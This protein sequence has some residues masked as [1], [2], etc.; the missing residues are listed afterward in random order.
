[1]NIYY[2]E[3]LYLV[4]DKMEINGYVLYSIVE[5]WIFAQVG[6]A[7]VVAVDSWYIIKRDTKLFEKIGKLICLK[8]H[9]QRRNTRPQLNIG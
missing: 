9:E 6:G 5:N 1:M 7:N 4:P 2:P 8:Q 3:L